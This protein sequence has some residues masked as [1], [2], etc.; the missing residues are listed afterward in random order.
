MLPS[1]F[2]GEAYAAKEHDDANASTIKKL[3][4]K[5]EALEGTI[6]N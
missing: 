6:E 3:N 5:I 4:N 2:N 1:R